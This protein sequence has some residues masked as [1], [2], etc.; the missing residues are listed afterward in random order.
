MLLLKQVHKIKEI[1]ILGLIKMY[2]NA[3]TDDF[4]KKITQNRTNTVIPTSS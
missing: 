2:L 4:H 3:A 1:S